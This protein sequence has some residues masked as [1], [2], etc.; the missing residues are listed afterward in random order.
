MMYIFFCF[1]ITELRFAK[2]L[3]VFYSTLKSIHYHDAWIAFTLT[4]TKICQGMFLLTDH[5][6]WISRSGLIKNIDTN[7][8]SYQSNRYWLLSLIMNLIRDIYE[9]NRVIAS[10]TSYK[11]LSSCIT[12]SLISIR[13]TK[14]INRCATS[15]V[16]FLVTYKHLTIDTMKNVCDLF[17]PLT[18]L[19]YVKLSPRII[20]LLGMLSSLLGLFVIIN[21]QCK[22]LPQ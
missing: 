9:I 20:G 10:F 21:P 7:K 11:N 2:S 19:G 18:S 5:I 3:D 22:L 1:I 13:S 4:A 16:E 14:D 17:I 8:W 6:I 15:V 12:S